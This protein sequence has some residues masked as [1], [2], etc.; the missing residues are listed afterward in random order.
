VS[1]LTSTQEDFAPRGRLIPDGTKLVATVENAAIEKTPNGSRLSR[2][3]GNLRHAGT[4]TNE[5]ALP[6]GTVFRLGNRKLFARSW[7]D[8]A[9]A[10]AAEIGQREIKREAAAAG[11]MKKPAKGETVHLD[12]DNWPLYA[13]TLVGRDV[14]VR[15]RHEIRTTPD[16]KVVMESDGVT[17]VVDVRVGDWLSP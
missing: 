10:Q 1:L 12:F 4:G 2:Q 9:N 11:L 6:D 3:Y 8:H 13:A 17:P 14:T 5:F 7:I 15:V 16:G